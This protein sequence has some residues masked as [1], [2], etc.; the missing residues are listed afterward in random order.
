[1]NGGHTVEARGDQL[2][3]RAHVHAAGKAPEGDDR[4]MTDTQILPPS[5]DDDDDYYYY[6]NSLM[7]KE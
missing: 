6:F 5:Y 7:C 3:V 1:M 4:Q 2:G